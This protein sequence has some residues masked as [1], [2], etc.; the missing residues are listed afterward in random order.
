M[1]LL[2]FS[3]VSSHKSPSVLLTTCTC[4]QFSRTTRTIG[5]HFRCYHHW[6]T[7]MY[8][9]RLWSS[10]SN[11]H[12]GSW[13]TP[14]VPL[15]HS[16]T[17]FLS[18]SS[19]AACSRARSSIFLPVVFNPKLARRALNSFVLSFSRFFSSLHASWAALVC[20]PFTACQSLKI[21]LSSPIRSIQQSILTLHRIL[22]SSSVRAHSLILA[23]SN[24]LHLIIIR[25][26]RLPFLF[27]QHYTNVNGQRYRL[28]S[29]HAPANPKLA[30]IVLLNISFSVLS[31]PGRAPKIV[32]SLL[33]LVYSQ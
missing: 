1:F 15:L 11:Q 29:H 22:V 30:R 5:R 4:L 33:Q 26:Q 6:T 2:I 18:F 19:M 25:L 31:N 21:R 32:G 13:C 28:L 27:F 3:A 17:S 8:L 16:L 9:R 24:F 23:A 20:W 10:I 14:R 7:L 12:M